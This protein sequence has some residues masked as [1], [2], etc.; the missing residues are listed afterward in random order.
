MSLWFG[1]FLAVCKTCEEE[2]SEL[3]RET[4]DE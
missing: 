1:N 3:N 4:V 2:D